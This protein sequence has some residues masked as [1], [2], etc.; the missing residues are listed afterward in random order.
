MRVNHRWPFRLNWNLFSL[1]FE[2]RDIINILLTLFFSVRTVS[3]GTSF[4]PHTSRLCHKSERKKLGP[5]LT[6]RPSNSISKKYV[7][8]EISALES[9]WNASKPWFPKLKPI[10]TWWTSTISVSKVYKQNGYDKERPLWCLQKRSPTSQSC[11]INANGGSF[12]FFHF[13]GA[14]R[15]KLRSLRWKES[16]HRGVSFVYTNDRIK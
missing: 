11:L 5:Y 16:C 12:K 9:L 2:S 6:V 4:F 15:Q 14:V 10:H 7:W 1:L 8:W 3:C 13:P